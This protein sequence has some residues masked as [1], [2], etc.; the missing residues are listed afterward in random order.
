MSGLLLYTSYAATDANS[1][2]MRHMDGLLGVLYRWLPEN[3]PD[4]ERAHR[5]VM[6]L[7]AKGCLPLD[8]ER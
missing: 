8:L 6:W 4:P 7:A 1:G 2:L 3:W 5:L